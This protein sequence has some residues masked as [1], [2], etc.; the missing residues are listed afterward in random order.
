M[1][2]HILTGCDFALGLRLR[3]ASKFK[4][5]DDLLYRCGQDNGKVCATYSMCMCNEPTLEILDEKV[6]FEVALTHDDRQRYD[7]SLSSRICF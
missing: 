6:F 7:L 2:T 5:V 4:G 3:C 1:Q